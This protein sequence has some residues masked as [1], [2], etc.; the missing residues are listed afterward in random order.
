[1]SPTTKTPR[2]AVENNERTVLDSGEES[3]VSPKSGFLC[4]QVSSTPK[5]TIDVFLFIREW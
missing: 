5:A 4:F 2:P 1:M 3:L